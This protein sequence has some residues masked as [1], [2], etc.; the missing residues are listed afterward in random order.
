M[1]VS[2]SLPVNL[3]QTVDLSTDQTNSFSCKGTI[4]RAPNPGIEVED[5]GIIGL[6]LSV[7]KAQPLISKCRQSPFGKVEETIVDDS[8]RKSWELNPS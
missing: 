2:P 5:L 4:A 8:V 6:P 1:V 7:R 3:L